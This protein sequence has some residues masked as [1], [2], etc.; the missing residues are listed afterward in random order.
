MSEE[1]PTHTRAPNI[2]VVWHLPGFTAISSI[3]IYLQSSVPFHNA[4]LKT[5]S[6][7]NRNQRLIKNS[8]SEASLA[9]GKPDTISGNRGP[10]SP[11]PPP[12]SVFSA[13]TPQRSVFVQTFISIDFGAI[14]NLSNKS[15][16]GIPQG[17]EANTCE[18]A[19]TATINSNSLRLFGNHSDLLDLSMDES[20]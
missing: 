6:A 16:L 15:H 9:R 3:P 1:T 12:K 7:P 5:A 14:C 2:H 20:R 4:R 19:E 11:A 13:V 18:R 8:K 10:T 17:P